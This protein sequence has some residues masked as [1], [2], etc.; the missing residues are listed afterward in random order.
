[1]KKSVL[2]LAIAT[3]L[4]VMIPTVFAQKLQRGP[5][6]EIRIEPVKE[7]QWE[8]TEI[9][10]T[11]SA[12]RYLSFVKEAIEKEGDT[13]STGQTAIVFVGMD[14]FIHIKIAKQ[15]TQGIVYKN[16]VV[17]V[18]GQYQDKP[19]TEFAVFII[20]LIASIIFMLI[21]NFLF[22][23]GEFSAAATIVSAATIVAAAVTIV[24][25]ATIVV[26][27]ATIVAVVAAVAAAVVSAAAAAVAA[28]EKNKKIYVI[29]SLIYYILMIIFFI[30]IYTT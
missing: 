27:A 25:A 15:Y 13:I 29:F 23:N 2:F 4:V 22:K 14:G 28:I 5:N 30:L 20:L 7:V 12:K 21:S 24:S 11:K 10:I 9:T 18:T 3:M 8:N 19:V 17:D 26:A 1:M 6:G 16:G